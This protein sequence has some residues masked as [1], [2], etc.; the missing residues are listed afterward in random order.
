MGPSPAPKQGSHPKSSRGGPGPPFFKVYVCIPRSRRDRPIQE[1]QTDPGCSCQEGKSLSI[2]PPLCVDSCCLLRPQGWMQ[3]GIFPA[4]S[5]HSQV[6]QRP[7]A[8]IFPSPYIDKGRGS[9][10]ADS[11]LVDVSVRAVRAVAAMINV[12]FMWC[13]TSRQVF[14]NIF[15]AYTRFSPTLCRGEFWVV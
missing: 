14:Q 3:G 1:G 12:K 11:R 7:L 2:I 5:P 15:V 4:V 13:W 6:C 9:I 8:R 10:P